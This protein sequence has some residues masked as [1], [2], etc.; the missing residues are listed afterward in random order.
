MHENRS[1]G[2]DRQTD[3]HREKRGREGG[4]ESKVQKR[5]MINMEQEVR[6][7]EGR[8]TNEKEMLRRG[9]KIQTKKEED[10]RDKEA[11]VTNERGNK[12]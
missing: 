12:D 11:I 4:Q 7:W 10:M 8:M 6:K 1:D 5:K 2:F 3:K 9:V